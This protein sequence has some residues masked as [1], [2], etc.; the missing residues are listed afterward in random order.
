MRIVLNKDWEIVENA[1]INARHEYGNMSSEELSEE[2][3]YNAFF[4]SREDRCDPFRFIDRW[5]DFEVEEA[6]AWFLLMT[7]EYSIESDVFWAL[8]RLQVERGKWESE[9]EKQARLAD[10]YWD[11]MC[12]SRMLN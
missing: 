11:M 10:E 8:T 6:T 9:E 1:L 7:G 2:L 5:R 3:L 12:D 4:I